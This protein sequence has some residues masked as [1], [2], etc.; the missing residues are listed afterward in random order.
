M[1][2]LLHNFHPSSP[3]AHHPT[4]TRNLQHHLTH[5]HKKGSLKPFCPKL[6]SLPKLVHQ[7]FLTI[8]VCP[9]NHITPHVL[10]LPNLSQSQSGLGRDGTLALHLT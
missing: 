1:Y 6:R 3:L 5:A 9:L 7:V 8:S 4:L 10:K 2:I